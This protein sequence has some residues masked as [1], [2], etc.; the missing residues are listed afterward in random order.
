[1]ADV[2]IELDQVTKFYGSR[3]GLVDLS[4][5][6]PRGA[7]VGLLGPN[8]SGK[9]T[10]M[11][12]LSCCI[13][14]TSGTARVC[15]LHV[16]NQS[17]EVRRTLGYLPEQCPL[18]PDMRVLEYLRWT[19]NMKG[20][21]RWDADR[22]VFD[23]LSPCG[24]EHVREQRI[25][26]LSR[27]YRQRV[28]LAS[29]L[30]HKPE[31]LILDEPTVGLD[32]L[33]VREFRRVI[34]GLKGRHTVVISS[35][36]LSEIEM[37]CDSVIILNEGWVVA[38][39]APDDLR[40]DVA[41]TCTVEC[42]N[43]PSLITLLPRMVD[44]LGGFSLQDYQENG[45]WARFRLHG[46]G[47]DPRRAIYQLLSES[48]IELNELSR[49]RLTLEDIFVHHTRGRSRAGHSAMPVAEEVAS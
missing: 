32:P 28:G 39:G 33:Q 36:I 18:Y 1:M 20:M 44:R 41:Y 31:V 26:T 21:R 30:V 15:G 24:I 49:E 5:R 42:R 47:P 25:G 12:I 40:S 27:G 38:S 16:F 14:P 6:I 34:G 17:L 8:G 46:T 35:H 23:V 9:T 11:R 7:L 3:P 19:A 4:A 29:V 22:A 43:H 2:A 48:G 13:P 45:E 37:L 10:T